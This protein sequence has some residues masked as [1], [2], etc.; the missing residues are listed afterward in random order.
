MIGEAVECGPGL[1]VNAVTGSV[2]E[3]PQK[4]LRH[5]G[6]RMKVPLLRQKGTVVADR[7]A[8]SLRTLRR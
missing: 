4:R 7:S 2:A 8:I 5:D 3:Q 6:Y 1:S